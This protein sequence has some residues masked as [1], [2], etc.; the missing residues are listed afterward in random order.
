M[1]AFK[2]D[3]LCDEAQCIISY[4]EDLVS[5]KEV[6]E[7][8]VE[9]H[10]HKDMLKTINSLLN[11]ERKMA[12]S[13]KEILEVTASISDFDMNMSHISEK[14]LD[15]SQ[16]M[17]VMSE[18]NLAIVEETNASMHEVNETVN[19]VTDT[20][21]HLSGQSEK[22]LETN[23][24]GIKE[25]LEVAKLKETVLEHANIMKEQIDELIEMTKKI[26][27]IVEGVGKIADQTNLLALNASIEAARAGEYGRGFAVVADEIRK[28]ADDT[29]KNL[30]GMN[31]FV[32]DIQ[33]SANEGKKSMETTIVS[34][35][36]MSSQID[37]VILTIQENVEMLNDSIKDIK[38][39]NTSMEGIRVATNE[40]NSAMESASR[41]AEELSNMTVKITDYAMKSKDYAKNIAEIDN[42]LSL[43]TRDMMHA[44]S[45][46][47]NSLSDEDILII[48]EKALTTHRD[49]VKRLKG[50]VDNMEVIPIQTD[51][52]RC[53]FGHYYNSAIIHNSKI[54]DLWRSIDQVHHGVHNGGDDTIAAI[55]SGDRDQAIYHFNRTKA[56]SEE[57][58]EIL[59][60]IKSL[61]T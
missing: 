48:I 40:I 23:N 6:E 10:I 25:L 42:K 2:K 44:L 20:L 53:A 41:E 1:F 51:G 9:Y 21:N 5:G 29:K 8:K 59:I 30:D 55:K 47:Q 31:I 24:E 18:S 11:N 17:S 36:Q 16:Q 61:L 3:N 54:L 13:A 32:G 27:Q 52:N 33:R 57:M 15:F 28:L 43:I 14:L 7:P 45:G 56:K 58:I 22:L 37:N 12:E 19:E 49:W 46:G 50:M 60:K 39:I 38:D 34:T 26:Y 35:N 4:V